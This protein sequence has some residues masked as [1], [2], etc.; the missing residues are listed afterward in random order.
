MRQ[1]GKKGQRNR[2]P[3]FHPKTNFLDADKVK[4]M[5]EYVQHLRPEKEKNVSDLER[6]TQEDKVLENMKVL[7]SVVE[8][9]GKSFLAADEK[10]QKASCAQFADTGVMAMVCRHDCPL[11]VVNMTSAGEK[12]HY[13]LALIDRLFAEIPAYIRVGMMYDIHMYLLL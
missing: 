4:R 10:R 7:E 6:V 3:I 8:E 2:I 1:E 13:R 5:E 11:F 12:Q 9:C